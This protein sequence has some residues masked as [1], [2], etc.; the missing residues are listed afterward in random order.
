M[1]KQN[2][3]CY[4]GVTGSGCLPVGNRSRPA[5]LLLWKD[6]EC[7]RQYLLLHDVSSF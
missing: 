2:I 1:D 7:V 5:G 3:L 4:Y 6:F